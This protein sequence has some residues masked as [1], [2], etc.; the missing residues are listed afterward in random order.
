MFLGQVELLE[1]WGMLCERVEGEDVE[2]DVFGESEC[3]ES[4]DEVL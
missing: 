4:V 3:V 2:F 1:I